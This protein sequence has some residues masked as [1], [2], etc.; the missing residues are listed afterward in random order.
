[1]QILSL[2]DFEDQERQLQRK[3]QALKDAKAVLHQ[4]QF[5]WCEIIM[6]FIINV[7]GV[8]LYSVTFYFY[9]I[10]LFYIQL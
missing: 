5:N 9:I 1:M 4:K 6:V 7:F 8:F 10:Y 3:K 2:A